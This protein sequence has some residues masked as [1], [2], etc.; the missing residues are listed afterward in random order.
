MGKIKEIWPSLSISFIDRTGRNVL[1]EVLYIK[2]GIGSKKSEDIRG[3][4]SP[5]GSDLSGYTRP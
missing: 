5:N 1:V 3:M 2:E 4:N